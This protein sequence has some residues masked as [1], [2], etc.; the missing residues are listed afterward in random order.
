M[1]NSVHKMSDDSDSDNIFQSLNIDKIK[2]KKFVSG[3]DDTDD[4]I[5]EDEHPHG[6]FYIYKN[7]SYFQFVSATIKS[8]RCRLLVSRTNQIMIYLL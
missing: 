3:W 1:C 8:R 7:Y 5:D 6:K 2:S 4:L